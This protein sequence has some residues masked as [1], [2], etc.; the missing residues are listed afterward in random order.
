MRHSSWKMHLGL[1]A[2]VDEDE[3]GLVALDQVVD[4]AERVPRG[5]AGPGQPLGGVEHG[6]VGRRAALGDTRSASAGAPS[7]LRHQVAA[8]IVGL[9]HGGGEADA[10]EL[11]RERETAAPARAR[12]DR[13]ACE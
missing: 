3:R 10:G 7:R 11:R 8:Q 12:A 13:R 4:L 1:A 2:G 6:D 5:M 9:G